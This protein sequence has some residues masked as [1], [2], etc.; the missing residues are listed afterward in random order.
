MILPLFEAAVRGEALA[1]KAEGHSPRLER[2]PPINILCSTWL[3]LPHGICA[4]TSI[5]ISAGAWRPSITRR[6]TC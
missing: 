3:I 6:T 5:L 4:S 1:R 2:I